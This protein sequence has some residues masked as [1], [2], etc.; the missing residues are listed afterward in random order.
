MKAL[1]AAGVWGFIGLSLVG[2]SLAQDTER[3]FADLASGDAVQ[4]AM[5][6]CRVGEKGSGLAADPSALME[7]L[8]ALLG[9][10]TEVEGRL[11]RDHDSWW[12]GRSRASSPGR[13]AAMALERFGK[14][15]L[16]PVVEVLRGTDDV[17]REHAAL[18]LGILEDPTAIP[19][20]AEALEREPASVRARA[21][22]SLG[23]IEDRRAVTILK[24]AAADSD[25]GVREETAWALG[26]IEDPSGVAP[27]TTLIADESPSVRQQAAWA[28]G[29]IE[30]RRG[31]APLIV[32]LKDESPDVR[33]EA[34]WGLGMI[35]DGT[36][37]DAL[38]DALDDPE[39]RVRKQVVWAISQ[40]I[41]DA[42]TSKLDTDALA[43]S[44]EKAFD[45][46]RE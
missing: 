43:A 34:A 30:D 7:A 25:A 6:A 10:A 38:V 4:R 35:E 22:W 12:D 5:A 13:E 31:V 26:M 32:A 29:M 19:A 44:L 28:L 24:R 11:C 20:L 23:R 45:R 36:A 1:R 8:I 16:T 17:S 9:D 14:R 2:I 46:R 27:L 41:A 40:V 18:A 37:L 3:V 21:A 15:A 42:D 39:A 33:R